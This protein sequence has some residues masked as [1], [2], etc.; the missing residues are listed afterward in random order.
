[1]RPMWNDETRFAVKRRVTAILREMLDTK[2]LRIQI[3]GIV[4][5]APIESVQAKSNAKNRILMRGV[6]TY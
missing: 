5:R 3:G 1:M 2:S 6:P 4:G